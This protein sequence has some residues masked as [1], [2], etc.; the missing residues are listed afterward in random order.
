[1][2]KKLISKWA[3]NKV[4]PQDAPLKPTIKRKRKGFFSRKNKSVSGSVDIHAAL[5][6]TFQRPVLLRKI[7]S[8]GHAMDSAVNVMDNANPQINGNFTWNG[9]IP[10]VQL[11]YYSNQSFIGYNLCAL[12]EQ[13]WLISKCCRMPAEDAVRNGYEV[14]VNDGSEIDPE[15]ISEITK[16]DVRFSLTKNLI[17]FIHLGRTFGIRVALFEIAFSSLDERNEFYENPFNI[18]AVKPGT[19]RGI[20]Q[21]D[22]YWMTYQLDDAAAGD[23]SSENFYEPTWWIINSRKI[24]H[25]HL[26]IYRTEELP[27]ILKTTYFYG[28]VPIPQKVYNRVYAAERCANEA[29]MLLLTKRTSVIKMD[30]TE[31]VVDPAS[32]EERM[33]QFTNFHDNYGVKTV[34]EDEEFTQ[35]DTALAEVNNITK[36]QYEL[37]AAAA[38]VPATKLLGISPH[39]GGHSNSTQ[40]NYEEA[41]YHEFLRSMQANDLTRMIERHHLLLIASEIAPTFNIAPFEVTIKWKALDEATAKEKAEINKIESETDANLLNT[42]AIDSQEIRERIIANPDSGYSGLS[43]NAESIETDEDDDKEDGIDDKLDG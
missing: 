27:D 41:S 25:T 31:A 43:G 34:G 17:E 36:G 11:L 40:G 23:P 16:A 13:H 5:N 6:R 3:T 30:V 4:T 29:P 22:P 19:Y 12:L 26:V 9:I 10:Q 35:F 20:S 2:L 39:G 14:T 7:L 32:L 21:I 37:V 28:G 38:G 18:D 1:V 42:G 8:E 33:Q 24:H 15:I